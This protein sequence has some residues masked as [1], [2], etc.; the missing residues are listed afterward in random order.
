MGRIRT[1]FPEAYMF[2]REKN[3][4]TFSNSILRGSYQLT[5]EPII[6]SSKNLL[7]YTL[8][9]YNCWSLTV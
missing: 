7:I 6:H 4:P 8:S 1:V 3:I 9:M 2:K 5:V